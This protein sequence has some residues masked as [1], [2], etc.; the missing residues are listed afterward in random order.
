MSVLNWIELNP[1]AL[2]INSIATGRW[3][4]CYLDTWI[5]GSLAVYSIGTALIL[6]AKASTEDTPMSISDNEFHW[7]ITRLEKKFLDTSFLTGGL[8]SFIKWPL[9]VLN[10]TEKSLLGSVLYLPVK[11]LKVSTIS[12]FLLRDSSESNTMFWWHNF[13][14]LFCIFSRAKISFLSHGLQTTEAY[15]RTGRMIVQ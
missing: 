8:K 1:P 12:L 2:F 3:Q 5:L 15:S 10:G 4:E 14:H 13:R 7:S 9:S 11:Y 6:L